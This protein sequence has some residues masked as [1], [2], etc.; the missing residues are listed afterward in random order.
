MNASA[1][2]RRW[3]LKWSRQQ[4]FGRPFVRKLLVGSAYALVAQASMSQMPPT[5]AVL[6]HP[7][8]APVRVDP[9]HPIK[10]GRD[11]Y[12]AESVRLH[13]QG[14]CRVSFTVDERGATH[15]AKLVATSGYE[16]IDKAC[17]DAVEGARFIPAVQ[18]GRR[19]ATTIQ[20][21][22]S[23]S[24]GEPDA[25]PLLVPGTSLEVGAD[26]YPSVSREAKQKGDCVVHFL[27]SEMGKTNDFS[28][29]QSTGFA[30][31]DQ[32]CVKAMQH[33]H[34]QPARKSY[35]PYAKWMDVK[36]NWTLPK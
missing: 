35:V 31:L 27:V 13:E 7:V 9:R 36:M 34:F 4:G 5:P 21:P 17:L 8:D 12:P 11:F 29:A 30:S 2:A 25:P 16:R 10:L 32:A 26:Y 20:L 1:A 18:G 24:F 28:L 15:D 23:W 14:Q 3:R 19:V 22:I 33:A 6:R